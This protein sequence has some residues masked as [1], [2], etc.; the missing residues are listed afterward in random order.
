MKVEDEIKLAIE[1]LRARGVRGKLHVVPAATNL[2]CFAP[3][4][5]GTCI[6]QATVGKRFV[7]VNEEGK[8]RALEQANWELSKL[9]EWAKKL[10]AEETSDEPDWF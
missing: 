7:V 1:D 4:D 8:K 3:C 9:N 10:G 5:R 6:C 2:H